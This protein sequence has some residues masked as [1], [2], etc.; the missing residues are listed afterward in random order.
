MPLGRI[1]GE[2]FFFFL[3]VLGGSLHFCFGEK[4]MANSE[5]VFSAMGLPC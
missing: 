2:F 1:H 4:K 3:N 5:K